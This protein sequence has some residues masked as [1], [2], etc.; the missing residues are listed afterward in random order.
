MVKRND[1]NRTLGNKNLFDLE[2]KV[3]RMKETCSKTEKLLGIKF[4]DFDFE[5]FEL[6]RGMNG[7]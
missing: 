7:R 5:I 1:K 4:D 2:V 6:L 3:K